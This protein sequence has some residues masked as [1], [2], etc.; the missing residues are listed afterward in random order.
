MEVE[1]EPLLLLHDPDKDEQGSDSGSDS[2]SEEALSESGTDLSEIGGHTSLLYAL[3]PHPLSTAFVAGTRVNICS[4]RR[5]HWGGFIGIIGC[6]DVRLLGLTVDSSV[7]RRRCHQRRWVAEY[8]GQVAGH[9]ERGGSRTRGSIDADR[10]M[11]RCER[12]MLRTPTRPKKLPGGR[13]T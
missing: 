3:K 13:T 7:C 4:S 8:G 2:E 12:T 11:Y 1:D 5:G 6:Y 10:T 9:R